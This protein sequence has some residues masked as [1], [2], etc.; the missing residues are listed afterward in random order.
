MNRICPHCN[1]QRQH[2]DTAPE[3]QCPVCAKAYD[4]APSPRPAG[5]PPR[6]CGRWL[7]VLLVLAVMFWVGSH[8]PSPQGSQPSAEAAADQ[9]EIRLYA[10]DWCGYCKRARAF[11]AA[12]GIRYTEYDIEK[13]TEA[14]REHQQLGGRGVPLI[15]VDGEVVH[16]FNE[17]ALRQLLSPWLKD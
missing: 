17:G 3:W 6:R 13:S 10:T 12:N 16:G 9:P 7:S 15:V 8:L 2:S 1:Y 5:A 4:K 11:F 14:R